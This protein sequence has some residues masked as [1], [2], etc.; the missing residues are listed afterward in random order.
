[1]KFSQPRNEIMESS[2][3][4]QRKR[5]ITHGAETHDGLLPPVRRGRARGAAGA[6]AGGGGAGGRGWGG[7]A[8]GAPPAGSRRGVRGGGLGSPPAARGRLATD[9]YSIS[10]EQMIVS[11]QKQIR[12]QVCALRDPRSPSAPAGCLV[13]QRTTSL[14]WQKQLRPSPTIHRKLAP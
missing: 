4:D 12:L 9:A 3:S 13:D 6:G 7:W 2:R 8:P 11:T 1:M 5:R 14:A 10:T